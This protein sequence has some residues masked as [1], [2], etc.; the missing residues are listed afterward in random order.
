MRASISTVRRIAAAVTFLGAWTLLTPSPAR[1]FDECNTQQ[2]IW[3]SC[4]GGERCEMMYGEPDPGMCWLQS[5]SGCTTTP[6]T[7]PTCYGECG[8]VD[9][10]SPGCDLGFCS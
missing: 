4:S 3:C 7:G 5:V 1:A 8:Q 10:V 9:E 6:E 2:W